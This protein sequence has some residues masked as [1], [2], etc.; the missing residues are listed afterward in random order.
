LG[1]FQP[2]LRRLLAELGNQS[3]FSA[4]R[5]QRENI[6]VIIQTVERLPR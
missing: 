6:E 5:E 1:D 4:V 2:E 3:V